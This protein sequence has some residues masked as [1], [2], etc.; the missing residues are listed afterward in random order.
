M[1]NRNLCVST[2]SRQKI[3]WKN[4]CHNHN[5]N[6]YS[7]GIV[8]NYYCQVFLVGCLSVFGRLSKNANPLLILSYFLHYTTLPIKLYKFYLFV[9]S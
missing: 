5:I 9:H 2:G 4:V 7:C 1:Y 8:N 3:K 6:I